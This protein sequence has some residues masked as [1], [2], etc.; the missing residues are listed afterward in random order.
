[1]RLVSMS[2]VP[3]L[4]A[5]ALLPPPPPAL[6]PFPSTRENP[7]LETRSSAAVSPGSPREELDPSPVFEK[8]FLL[9]LRRELEPGSSLI[10]YE[11]GERSLTSS[12]IR[13][14][15]EPKQSSV[16]IGQ[17]Q[18][19]RDV[20][21]LRYKIQQMRR[22][23]SPIKPLPWRQTHQT[24]AELY[25]LLLRPFEAELATSQRLLLVPDGPLHYLP[26]GALVRSS[27]GTYHNSPEYLVYWK[28][29]S[30]WSADT[31]LEDLHRQRG[32][33]SNEPLALAA[34]GT[35]A[36]TPDIR[37]SPLPVRTRR[38][39]HPLAAN[40]RLRIS[41]QRPLPAIRGEIEDILAR[42]PGPKLSFLDERATE[43]AVR[44]F[45]PRARI[46][47]FATHSTFRPGQSATLILAP[48]VGYRS[49]ANNGRLMDREISASLRLDADL[50]V[51]SSCDSGRGPGLADSKI[52]GLARAFQLAG[53]RSVVASLWPVDDRATSLLMPLFYRFL[54]DGLPKDRALQAAQL[55]LI[56]HVAIEGPEACPSRR[57]RHSLPIFWAPFQV[58]G[59][60]S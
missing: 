2:P 9:E 10:V 12:L 44:A 48:P 30:I 18:L 38:G 42:V 51:L 29:F 55:A 25:D 54:M 17:K 13:P 35:S 19:Q 1:M 39:A 52:L 16:E 58:Y 46:L 40:R 47:H 15:F 53:A 8:P 34:F 26:W 27:I 23:W 6:E 57:Y 20:R 7:S 50:V 33:A 28:P 36:P 37:S 32:P 24:A 3:C 59:H 56:E 21:R 60:W 45:A 49:H 14:D 11:V 4:L 43:A 5:I 41:S 22:R 31:I